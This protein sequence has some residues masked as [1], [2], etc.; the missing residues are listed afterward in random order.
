MDV[1]VKDGKAYTTD[2]A[3]AG[4]TIGLFEAVCNLKKFCDIPLAQALCCATV[5]PA[6]AARIDHLVG[7]FKVGAYADFCVLREDGDTVS[8]LATYVGG[9]IQGGEA[10][11]A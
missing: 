10:L 5:N 9:V 8:L 3:I 4:S 7:T 11:H 1:I 2:G 6:R